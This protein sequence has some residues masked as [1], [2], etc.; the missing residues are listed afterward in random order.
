[1]RVITVAWMVVAMCLCASLSLAK[2][3]DNSGPVKKIS[4]DGNAKIWIAPDRARVF[5]GVETQNETLEGARRTNAETMNRIMGKLRALEILDLHV[6]SPAY[7]VALVKEDEHIAKKE[8]RLPRILGYK[9]IQKFTV[10]I[11]NEDITALSTNAGLALDTA[12]QNGVNIIEQN[13]LFFK[14]DISK[15]KEEVLKLALKDAISRANV[16][17]DTAGMTI[18]DYS[19]ISSGFFFGPRQPSYSQ[20]SQIHSPGLSEGSASTIMA[21]KIPV[22]A[23]VSLNC[24]MK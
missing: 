1:M 15:E 13:I 18:K 16:I 22:E 7:N 17:A 21:A 8:M 9:V 24:I 12:L 10:L 11:K 6:Q 19:M 5:L 23:S 20:V 2:S 4:T 14:E 3:S